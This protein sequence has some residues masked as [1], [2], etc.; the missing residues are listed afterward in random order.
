[1]HDPIDDSAHYIWNTF[2]YNREDQRVFVPKRARPMGWTI[3][4]ARPEIYL[5]LA[6][7]LVIFLIR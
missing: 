7:V 3:N 4:F 1:M 2:Y 5:I 6:V